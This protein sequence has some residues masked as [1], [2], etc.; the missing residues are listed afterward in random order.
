MTASAT[1]R[2]QAMA[3]TAR[4]L[5]PPIRRTS[6][7]TDERPEP[8]AAEYEAA[9]AY[10]G[11]SFNELVSNPTVSD[12]QVRSW[13][14]ARALLNDYRNAVLAYFYLLGRERL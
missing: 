5:V 7:P 1:E 14:R 11:I 8:S 13:A 3:S 10:Y 12:E 2:M 9:L 4:Q 6:H